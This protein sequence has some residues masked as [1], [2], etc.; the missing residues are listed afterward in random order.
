MLRLSMFMP[1]VATPI[2][3]SREVPLLIPDIIQ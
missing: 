2:P 3:C 1:S